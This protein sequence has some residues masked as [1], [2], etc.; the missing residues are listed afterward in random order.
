M[1]VGPHAIVEFGD[2]SPCCGGEGACAAARF[3]VTYDVEP[4]VAFTGKRIDGFGFVS[5]ERYGIGIGTVDS[6]RC[7]GYVSVFCVAAG[8]KEWAGLGTGLL[9]YVG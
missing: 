3:A 7:E 6:A 8:A 4:Q 9:R 5:G 2:E 1:R